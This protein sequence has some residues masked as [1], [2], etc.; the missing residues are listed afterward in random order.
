MK[1]DHKLDWTLE[2]SWKAFADHFC[3][4]DKESLDLIWGKYTIK[5]NR[6]LDY[7][8]SVNKFAE[9]NFKEWLNIYGNETSDSATEEILDMPLK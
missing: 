8:K 2:D 4:V 3:V 9:L 5:E 6:W 1:F 7:S